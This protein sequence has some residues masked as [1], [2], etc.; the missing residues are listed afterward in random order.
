MIVVAVAGLTANA[1]VALLLRSHAAQSL[2]VRGA[3]LEVI[4]D[5]VG[6]VGVLTAGLVTVTTRWPYADVV[7]AVLVALWV[8]PRAY[9]LARAALRILSESSPSHIDVEALRA[10]LCAVD[11]VDGVHDL[12]VW[13]L[14]PGKDCRHRT[15]DQQRGFVQSA[16]RSPRSGVG[17][18][19]TTRD[20]SGGAAGGCRRLRGQLVGTTTGPSGQAQ[21]GPGAGV[22][23]VE[24]VQAACMLVGLADR[25]GGARQRRYAT[26]ET[27][28]GLMRVRHRTKTPPAV[29]PQLIQSAVITGTG[30]GVSGDGLIVG[31]RLFGQRRPGHRCRRMRAGHDRG[32]LTGQ[33]VGLGVGVT[34]QQHGVWPQEITR[35]RHSCYCAV[36]GRL[37]GAGE[38]RH[39]NR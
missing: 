11:G 37:V 2:A 23:V 38:T 10:A 15:S 7:V 16:R 31:Q 17:A 21:R 9:G 39:H 5:T 34:G 3:Y 26:Q 28:V 18:R 19:A 13:T 4:A 14:V 30:V 6:T 27:A 8:L 12:H 32:I 29:T 35:R 1:V 36:P 25:V 20:H 22:T 24:Q 33:Q